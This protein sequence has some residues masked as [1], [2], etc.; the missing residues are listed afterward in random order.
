MFTAKADGSDLYVIDPS[1]FTS[2]FVWRDP[3]HVFAWAYY[4]TFKERFYLFKDKT[5]EVS[6]IG[7]DGWESPVVFPGPAGD[8]VSTPEPP[9]A[10]K[11]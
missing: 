1:G 11:P 5:R 6:A 7:P 3:D 9:A 10:P 2:H 8:F 4:P